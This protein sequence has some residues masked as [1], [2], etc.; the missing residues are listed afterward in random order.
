MPEG[1]A[2]TLMKLSPAWSLPVVIVVGIV[3]SVIIA[4]F[5]AKLF[6]LEK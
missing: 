5:I 4:N 3:V 6:K 2:D 1:Y